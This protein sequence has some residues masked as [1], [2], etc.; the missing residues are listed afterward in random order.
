M[1]D[2]GYFVTVE[3]QARQGHATAT[4]LE[5]LQKLALDSER[6]PGCRLFCAYQDGSEPGRFVLWERFESEQAFKQHAAEAHSQ[7]FNALGL[8]DLVR[9]SKS[10][11]TTR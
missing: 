8:V 2:T 9:V 11:S 7:A 1:T 10:M 4:V 3:L 6:E 5:A